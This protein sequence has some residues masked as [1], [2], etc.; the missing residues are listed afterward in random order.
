MRHK[1]V[2]PA[3]IPRDRGKIVL[4]Q[5]CFDLIH[6]GH[7]KHFLSAKSMGDIL[8]VAVTSDKYVNKGPGRPYFNQDLRMEQLASLQ[9]VD[10]VVL[11]DSLTAID[12]IG[13]VRPDIFVKGAEYDDPA[14]D[15]TGNIG[16]EE[17]TVKL[18]GGETRYTHDETFSSSEILNKVFNP[19]TPELR[20]FLGVSGLDIGL[21]L[22]HLGQLGGLRVLVVGETILDKYTFVQTTGMPSK[23]S[24]VSSRFEGEEVNYGGALATARH[25]MQ[26]CDSVMFFTQMSMSLANEVREKLPNLGLDIVAISDNETIVKER[27]LD[28]TNRVLY[29]VDYGRDYYS[30]GYVNEINHR[31]K[32]LLDASQF[33][34]I[35]ANDFGHGLLTRSTIDLLSGSGTFLAVNTQ[36][37]SLNRGFNLITKYPSADYISIDLPEARL[38]TGL[39]HENATVL[40]KEIGK[41][42]SCNLI[43]ITH[44][45]NGTMVFDKD[46]EIRV[47]VFSTDVIDT[48]GAG[49]A[50]FSITSMLAKLGV[51]KEELGFV[52]NAVGSLTTRILGNRSPVDATLLKKYVKALLK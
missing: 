14:N 19:L 3:D 25:A 32:S 36:T 33:D 49:D 5:G 15:V 45:K 43:S 47:P 35:I 26:F 12:I 31:L 24:V 13:K 17:E 34:L 41:R 6:V 10:Y 27:F 44:G 39:R 52:G 23:Q 29:R 9:A 22:G 8:V 18:L 16:K 42:V 48:T 38:A 50:Y 4:C 51:S 46:G 28:D 7:M 1:I 2:Q 40:A 11:S 20:G 37:N 30:D 21:L